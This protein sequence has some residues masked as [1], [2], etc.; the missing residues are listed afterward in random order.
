MSSVILLVD[1][2][3]PTII[4]FSVPKANLGSVDSWGWELSLKW[5]DRLNSNFRYWIG[6]N[7]SYNQ[8]EIIEK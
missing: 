2:T 4:G 8:N 7:L 5:N 3:A 6:A 1:E